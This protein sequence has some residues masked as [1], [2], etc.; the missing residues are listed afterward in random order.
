MAK[1]TVLSV[2]FLAVMSPA[3]IAFADNLPPGVLT[4]RIGAQMFFEDG[5]VRPGVIAISLDCALG[6]CTLTRTH[7]FECIGDTWEP[8]NN[9][10]NT[11]DGTLRILS[12]QIGL[13]S[14]LGLATGTMLLE[15][16]YIAAWYHYK[17]DFD[18][19]LQRGMEP[20]IQGLTGF[21]GDGAMAVGPD[22]RA[23]T[24]MFKRYKIVPLKGAQVRIKPS[25]DLVLPG[26]ADGNQR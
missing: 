26:L 24:I 10:S 23:K 25:C 14:S 2:M 5:K 16:R 18:V 9:T 8:F 21:E 15:E 20:L 7:L 22:L 1:F 3:P 6:Q 12:S 4:L 13:P 11:K 17:F 19:F